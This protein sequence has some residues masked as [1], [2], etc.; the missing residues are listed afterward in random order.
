MIYICETGI[1]T[2][3]L[4]RECGYRKLIHINR[5]LQYSYSHPPTHLWGRE[6]SERDKTNIKEQLQGGFGFSWP[7]LIS[8]I[9]SK[10]CRQQ[11]D[12]TA[13]AYNKCWPCS[14][15]VQ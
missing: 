1:T 8:L 4:R 11:M 10:T 6:N 7:T 5:Y 3:S 15:T 9:D 12:V 13:S 14:A 2:E